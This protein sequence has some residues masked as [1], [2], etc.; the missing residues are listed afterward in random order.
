VECPGAQRGEVLIFASSLALDACPY[1][2]EQ[3]E[4]CS[5][6]C[7]PVSV[8]RMTVGTPPAPTT[9]HPTPTAAPPWSSSP[10]AAQIASG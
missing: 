5:A 4:P 7:V 1:L 2:S 9:N 10:A 3:S 6:V 8:S